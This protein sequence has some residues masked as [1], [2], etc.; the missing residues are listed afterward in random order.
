MSLKCPSITIDRG[1]ISIPYLS[2]YIVFKTDLD[3]FVKD[4]DQRART[5]ARGIIPRVNTE[6]IDVVWEWWMRGEGVRW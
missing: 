1:F 5:R 3:P 4:N 2:S 6:Y